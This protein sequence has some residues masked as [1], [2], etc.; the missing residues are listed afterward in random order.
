MAYMQFPNINTAFP[1]GVPASLPTTQAGVDAFGA[2]LITAMQGLR[3]ALYQYGPVG[4]I[5]HN[6]FMIHGLMGLG[7]ESQNGALWVPTYNAIHPIWEEIYSAHSNS[8]WETI[9]KFGFLPP[10][11]PLDPLEIPIVA[12][13]WPNAGWLTETEAATAAPLQPLPEPGSYTPPPRPMSPNAT[14]QINATGQEITFLGF[15]L[16][17]IAIAAVAVLLFINMK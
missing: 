11:L 13:Y 17:Q 4:Q 16:P 1:E 2:R 6:A 9:R 8:D 10:A 14:G 3:D 15:S 5:A 12:T 7:Y